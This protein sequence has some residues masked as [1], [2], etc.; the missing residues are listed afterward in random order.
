MHRLHEED[1]IG[2]VLA[3]EPWGVVCYPAIAE[4]DETH[5]IEAALETRFVTRARGEA[6]HRSASRSIC[7]SRFVARLANTISPACISRRRRRRAAA[8]SRRRGLRAI[9]PTNG[10]SR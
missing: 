4:Q 3:Q 10:R 7:S 8:W 2:H 6:L 1:L 5:L 9:G